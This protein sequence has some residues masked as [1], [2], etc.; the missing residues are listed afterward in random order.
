MDKDGKNNY[1]RSLTA[2]GTSHLLLLNSATLHNWNT[3]LPTSVAYS[4]ILYIHA[5]HTN[6]WQLKPKYCVYRYT[7]PRSF[8][9]LACSSDS[10]KV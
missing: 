5:S 4:V 7:Y 1:F 3:M 10:T 6:A 8:M 2:K 9:G